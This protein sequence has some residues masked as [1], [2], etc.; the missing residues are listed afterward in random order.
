MSKPALTVVEK[1][2]LGPRM[3]RVRIQVDHITNVEAAS[4]E[5]AALE[6]YEELRDDVAQRWSDYVAEVRPV[7]GV[8][9]AGTVKLGKAT[10]VPLE[11]LEEY[12]ATSMSSRPVSRSRRGS[13]R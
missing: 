2:N 1:P 4:E 8:T 11:D 7:L 10:D 12:V 3:Y 13:L 6:A 9:K 5:A